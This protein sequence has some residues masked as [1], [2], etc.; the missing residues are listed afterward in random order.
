MAT[1]SNQLSRQSMDNR[2]WMD[3]FPH[4]AHPVWLE[5]PWQGALGMV[6][7]SLCVPLTQAWLGGPQRVRLHSPGVCGALP[8]SKVGGR[9]GPS[10]KGPCKHFTSCPSQP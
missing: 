6:S 9:L 5:P 2:L 7:A 1:D 3:M 8:A 10:P 4:W